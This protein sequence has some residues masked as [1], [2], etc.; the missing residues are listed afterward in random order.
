MKRD[1]IEVKKKFT[2]FLCSQITL[3]LSNIVTNMVFILSVYNRNSSIF[4]ASLVLV[5]SSF[6]QLFGSAILT[7]FIDSYNRKHLY[8]FS[9]YFKFILLLFSYL[10]FENIGA[11]FVIRFLL[12]LSDSIISPV[13]S[14]ILTQVLTD[15][16]ENR[17]KA[18][19]FFIQLYKF[20]KPVHGWLV[21]QL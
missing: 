10:Y 9:L 19:V 8:K 2:Y 20:F 13:Q 18:M 15:E 6:A 5:T 21:F 4:Q 16:Y 1:S 11:L 3:T 14:V 17:V 7:K 12:S